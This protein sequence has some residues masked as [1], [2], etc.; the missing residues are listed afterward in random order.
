[1][2]YS[3]IA[4]TIADYLEIDYSCPGISVLGDE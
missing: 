3:D 4:A 1:M 2:T